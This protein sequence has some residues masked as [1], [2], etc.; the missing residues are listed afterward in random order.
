MLRAV[1]SH[2]WYRGRR[3]IVRGALDELGL[4][5]AARLLDAGC[6]AGHMLDLLA[7]FGTAI[8]V[9]SDAASVAV[10]IE[11]GRDAYTAALPELPFPDGSFD[12]SVCLDVLEH[13]EDDVAA[14]TELARVTKPDGALLIT[15]PAYQSLW[16]NHDVVNDHMR[17]YRAGTLKPV[18]L[19]A[20][21][22]VERMTYFNSL[23][24]PPAALVR[25]TERWR[26]REPAKEHSSDLERTPAVLNGLLELP[27]RIEAA[28]LAGGKRRLPAGLSLLAVL[29]REPAPALSAHVGGRA[30]LPPLLKTP[31]WPR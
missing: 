3:R 23:L 11:C 7:E 28:I 26:P 17:R 5:P 16:S 30:Q 6:A 2:W 1:D 18:A 21:W 31:R 19:R 25:L 27:M 10:A 14:L 29:R 13:I 20:G 4:P 9:D 22:R 8:G 12:A 15:V 24:L